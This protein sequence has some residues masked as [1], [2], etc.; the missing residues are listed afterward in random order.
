MAGSSS[1]SRF[2]RKILWALRLRGEAAGDSTAQVLH[3]L[4]LMLLLLVSIHI[5]LAE[6][7]NR[8]KLLI[9]AIGVPMILTPVA[10]LIL[11]RKNAVR[12][13][14][15]VYLSGMW[16]AFTAII[17]LNGGIH[18]V[19][20]AV[21]IALAVSAAWLFGYAAALWT[22]AASCGATLVMAILETRQVGPWRPLP[23]TAF[24]VWM[25]VIEST[26][27]GVVPVTLVLSSLRRALAQSQ[28][29]EAELKAHQQHLEEQVQQRTAELV[30]ARDQA[31]AANQ[32]KSAFLANMSHELRTPLN[33]ILGFSR[34]VRDDPGLSEKHRK[35]L[36]IVNRSGEHLLGMIDDVLDVAKIEA[37]RVELE[38]TSLHLHNLLHD[39][40][41]LL[42]PRAA[43]KGL[44]L[45]LEQSDRV[46][47]FIRADAGKLRQTLINLI[48]NAVK[49]TA[50]GGIVVTADTA[51]SGTGLT[52]VLEVSDTG[53]GIAAED[54]ARIFDPFVQAGNKGAQKG[55]G[56]GLA[57][58]LR[59]VELM[60]G[61]LSLQSALG[62]GSVFRIE[63]PVE[64][65][66]ESA[67]AAPENG[68]NRVV[69]L[70]AGQPE[71]RVQIVEDQPENWMVLERI[72]QGAG[73]QVRVAED[74]ERGVELFISWQPHFIWM[75]L[76][77]P[78]IDGVEAERRIRAQEGG[79]KVKI[80]AITS[81]AFST[82][83]DAVLAAGF[84]GFL[85]KPYRPDEIFDFMARLLDVHY[86]FSESSTQTQVEPSLTHDSVAALPQDLREELV[87]AVIRL[88]PALI[89]A[90]IRRVS[91]CD[92]GLA[93][94][95]ARYAEQFAYSKILAAIKPAALRAMP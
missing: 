53:I 14:G 11:L 28:R 3:A 17:L 20:L 66:E 8:N 37:G 80:V 21:Y 51:G 16:V 25:L 10:T 32:A 19:G 59:F 34:L 75:D 94:V 64:A 70:A 50:E 23:G 89:A 12:S 78:G 65:M 93:I 82:Q 77:L 92:A 9:T 31:Q 86:V 1:G 43:G 36:D 74:G 95:L 76:R 2:L 24:G 67:P 58:T 49:Y 6:I 88:E 55:T 35:D 41:E 71:Y 47:R 72:L 13:A 90:A 62:S 38:I 91:A 52:L 4:V 7:I 26:L 27:M 73:F 30:E 29:A 57:I 46:P 33:A 44:R 48:G 79:R 54:Q 22:A 42:R 69:G 61:K 39:S 87:D 81:S 63:M 18:H 60:K 84:D 68:R 83:R 40:V 56:L 85:R 5:G 15:I 45:E